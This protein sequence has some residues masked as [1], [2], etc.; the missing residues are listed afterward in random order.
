MTAAGKFARNYLGPHDTAA[1]ARELDEIANR[2]KP[3]IC[4]TWGASR[5]HTVE[6]RILKTDFERLIE[7]AR[8][9]IG[10]DRRSIN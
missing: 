6:G 2:I 4:E 5:G 8:A 10:L 7:L 1:Q 3:T 9:G